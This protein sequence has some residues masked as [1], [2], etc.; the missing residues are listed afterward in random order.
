MAFQRWN[1]WAE[2][3]RLRQELDRMFERGG[4]AGP[5]PEPDFPRFNVSRSGDGVVI[6]ALAPGIERASLD[7]T[8]V[9]DTV[10]IR[11]ERKRD[12]TVAE[13]RYLRR[14]RDAGRFARSVHLDGRLATDQ[15][16]ATYQDGILRVE[17]PYAAEARPHTVQV[18]G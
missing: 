2:M 1:P 13:D 18:T 5:E 17:V 9:G 14:E 11:G 8:A 16:K 3:E 6:E 4:I 7:I 10:T 12:T 15:A